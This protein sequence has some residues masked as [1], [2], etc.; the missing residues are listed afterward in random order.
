MIISFRYNNRSYQI[1]EIDWKTNP[2]HIFAACGENVSYVEYYNSR[3]NIRIMDMKQPMLISSHM[4][5]DLGLSGTILHNSGPVL[6]VPELCSIV[7]LAGDDDADKLMEIS[8]VTE[9]HP[10]G[11]H[12]TLTDLIKDIYRLLS[13][14]CL[15]H[16][17]A[18]IYLNRY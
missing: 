18:Y 2:T 10:Q 14:I 17:N 8:Q 4:D 7:G 5:K 9:V 15:I 6:L 16:I 3:Y 1:D 11:R 13:G 12:T